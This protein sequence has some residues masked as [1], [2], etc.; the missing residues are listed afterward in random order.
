MSS[1]KISTHLDEET[2]IIYQYIE[3]V[4]DEEDSTKLYD[5]T[6]ALRARL[7]DQNKIRILTV[8]NKIGKS[9]SKARK[10]L[11]DNLQKPELY[12]MAVLGRNPY[13]RVLFTFILRVTGVKKA[14]MF[15]DEQDAVRWLRE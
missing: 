10:T 4:I 6:E 3:G 5:L 8:S 15:N 9:T 1:A 14:K 7:K 11:L 12:K 2:Q 13:M